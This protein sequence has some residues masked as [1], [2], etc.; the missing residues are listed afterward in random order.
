MSSPCIK[1]SSGNPKVF[2]ENSTLYNLTESEPAPPTSWAS[3]SKAP[4]N[5]LFLLFMENSKPIPKSGPITCYFTRKQLFSSL[6]SPIL[7]VSLEKPST[8]L[9]EPSSPINLY[10][11]LLCS[12]WFSSEDLL[13]ALC[14]VLS[15]S[16]FFSN[17]DSNRTYSVI[18]RKKCWWDNTCG[19]LRIELRAWEMTN[20]G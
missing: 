2:E 16:F 8:L 12:V 17:E 9:K 11:L 18:V 1:I 4:C 15:L 19:V 13:I 14:L 10:S 7:Q 5:S 6:I 3:F 20:I